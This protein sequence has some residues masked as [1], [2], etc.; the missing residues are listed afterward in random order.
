MSNPTF[1]TPGLARKNISDDLSAAMAGMQGPRIT[2]FTKRPF[3]R[4]FE[5]QAALRG[6]KPAVFC[7]DQTLTF[8]ELNA[9]ANQL[10]RH[11]RAL[12]VAR[13]SLVGICIDRSLQMAVTILAVLK[14]GGAYLPLD[15]DYPTERLRFMLADAQPVLVLTTSDIGVWKNLQSHEGPASSFVGGIESRPVFLDQDA[16]TISN[17]S[18]AN[19]SDGPTPEDL[20][21]VIYTSGSTGQPKGAMIT[22]GNLANYLLGLDHELNISGDDVYLHTAA[23]AF[24]SARRQ[25]MLPLSQ[26]A[27]VMIAN[28]EQRKDPLAL[29]NMIK[30]RGVTVMD[31]VP[32]FWR[33]CTTILASLEDSERTHLLN[34]RLRLML[35][36][37]EPLISDIPQ[38]WMRQFRHP[39]EHVHMFGQ[40]ETAGIVCLNRITEQ[41][42][43]QIETVPIGRPIA[44]TEIYLVNEHGH[45][46]EN[47]E[48][49]ELYIGGAGVG[50][51]YLNRAELTAQKFIPHPF[52]KQTDRRLYR[53][54]DWARVRPD[55]QIEFVGRRDQ[56]IKLRGFR[57]ELTEIELALTKHPAVRETV[58]IARADSGREKR[59]IAYFVA[60][61]KPPQ[62]AELRQFLSHQLPD[63]LIPAA[64]VAMDALPLSANGKIDRLALPD[65]KQLQRDL[66]SDYVA[67]QNEIQSRLARI[68]RDVLGVER[69][70]INDNFFELGGDSLSAAQVV[71]RARR[72]LRIEIPL[73]LLFEHSTVMSLAAQLEN[74]TANTLGLSRSIQPVAHNGS[75]PLSFTQQQFWLLDQTA[76]KRSAYNLQSAIRIE[77]KL[78]VQRLERAVETI[79]ARHQVLRTNF[80]AHNEAPIQ[81]FKPLQPIDLEIQDLEIQS[82]GDQ[83]I[84]VKRIRKLEAETP[85]DL[86]QDALVRFRLLRLNESDY[87]LIITIHHIVCDGWSLGI[88]HREIAELYRSTEITPLPIQ[89]ADF[90]AWQRHQLQGKT[91]E[92]LVDYWKQTLAGAPSAIELPTDFPRPQIPSMNGARVS[93]I[94]PAELSK[95]VMDLSRREGTTLFMT[96]LAA[97]QILLF[98]YSRQEDILV[99]SPIAGRSMLETENLIGAFVNTLVLRGDASGNPTFCEF[100]SRIRETVLSAF[101]HQELPFEKLVEELRPER[102]LNRSPLF[103]VMFAMQNQPAGL[104][105]D[106]LKVTPLRFQSETSKF[107]LSLEIEAEAETL[108]ASLEFNCD[109]FARQTVE[110]ML[111]HFQNL[112][113]GIIADPAARIAE[114]PLLSQSERHQLL[115]EWNDTRT[116]FSENPCLHH[117]FEAQVARTPE[118]IAAEFAGHRLTYSE[119]NSRA[120]QLAHYLREQGIGPEI[121][122][123]VCFERSLDMLVAILGVL[124]AGGAY[125]PL[126]PNYPRDRIGFMIEDAALRLV[127]TQ[128]SLV[129]A[130][131]QTTAT[132]ICLD[133]D[134]QTLAN[135]SIDNPSASVAAT[136]L[137]YAIYTSGSTGKPKGVMIEHRQIVNFTRVA[138]NAYEIKEGDRVL[139]FASLSFDL[140]AEEIYPALSQ[141]A[142]VVLRT[143]AMISSAL[144]FCRACEEL[145]I[146]VLDLPTAYWHELTDGLGAA[147]KAL[148]SSLRLVII[149]GEKALPERVRTWKRI[150]GDEVRLVN[151]YGPTETTVAVTLCDI[152]LDAAAAATSV[153]IGRPMANSTA[154]VLDDFLQP[155]P[156]GVAG[157]LY[158][159]GAGVGRGYISQSELTAE[160]FIDNPFRRGPNERLYRT[161]DLV[162]YRADGNLEFLGRV[163]NQIKIRGFRV[164]LEEI[165]T[166][167]RNHPAVKDCVITLREDEDGDK[168]LLAYVVSASESSTIN[169][170][171]DFLRSRLPSYMVP[172]LFEMIEA[173][174]LMPNG[175]IDRRALP[176]P[177][178]TRLEANESLVMPRTLLER[179]IAETWQEALKLDQVGVYE[180]FF[181]LGGHSLLAARVVS[182]LRTILHI[183]IC[184]VDIFRAPTVASLALLLDAR[185]AAEDADDELVA[186]LKELESLTEEAAQ[187]Q[188]FE[189]AGPNQSVSA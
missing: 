36:A 29:F 66:S 77:G 8:V 37:S 87:I 59:L 122:V 116:D 30:E 165:E 158:I 176:E 111:E 70:S 23:I 24:S 67:P 13:E 171:R 69:L 140:S 91:T 61:G 99:G 76:T 84:E 95:S 85:F 31:T 157:E 83:E 185:G 72:E 162:R 12:G 81:V 119:L 109:L 150:A 74:L 156:I 22:H 82:A 145:K 120:N 159:G 179:T 132:I 1:E 55:C 121:F 50:R 68:W 73:R 26:G 129:E 174:P 167:L 183:Q 62:A 40:T 53:T 25:L 98:R 51:G 5:D 160:K 103:Q 135:L 41:A 107:D 46:C 146:S 10:A 151:S 17:Y 131:P 18:D 78:D 4:L 144:D 169:E 38:T 93:A 88:L 175:K 114:L 86:S 9:R 80:V 166:A 153:L 138:A 170:M 105:I 184:M 32:S 15:P 104:T 90:A 3:P 101:S 54:G 42:G 173:F 168:R 52:C 79:V 20:A 33:N 123:G 65:A 102:K 75:A 164:E 127:L 152:V 139:Q 130:L 117:L 16:L 137:A 177:R 60:N 133:E 6:D 115:F 97:F 143:D 44:N 161:G 106:G 100:L 34:N 11:L 63:Y 71:A 148:P 124:K 112:L 27:A 186:L 108:H 154:Y 147:G 28:S 45:L 56:Q 189:E 48:A 49:G 142:T 188:L 21:Y 178:V 155:V 57:V 118:A 126:D 14:A 110:H 64:F 43:N 163:D 181:D 58:V 182:N 39:A 94:L 2:R 47:G 149:G 89:Y 141:G 19:L 134:R 96:L 128:R 7:D 113:A 180:N 172:A 125:V 136:N 92:R 35:S 187:A